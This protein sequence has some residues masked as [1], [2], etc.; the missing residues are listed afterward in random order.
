MVSI[1][2]IAWRSS[3]LAFPFVS[4]TLGKFLNLWV[5]FLI[6]KMKSIYFIKL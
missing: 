2:T 3:V 6:Q 4:V 1:K 5:C